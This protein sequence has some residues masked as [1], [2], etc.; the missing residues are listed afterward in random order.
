MKFRLT[1]SLL[2][3]YVLI[4]LCAMVLLPLSFPI[5]IF[6]ISLPT[7]VAGG[8]AGQG[9]LYGN[10]LQLERMWHEEAGKLGGAADEAIDRRLRELKA[11]Y[12][13]ANLFWVDE[14]GATRL[15]LPE[16]PA[17]PA[18]WTAAFTVEFMK[19]RSG[20]D[21]FT[22][23]AFLG[24]GADADGSFMVFE[25]PRWALK[26]TAERVRD[27]NGTA[28]V[29]G[30]L[31]LFGSFL[32]VSLLF[33]YRIR[34]RL[35][36]LQNAMT[37]P[38]GSGI[39]GE[40]EVLKM[41]EIG[42]LESA[43]NDMV[44]QLEESRR[45]EAEEETLRRDLF[46][47]LSHD[48]R[49]PLTAIR[50]H[51]YGLRNEPL[52]DKAA[53]S[54][55][56]IERKTDYAGR[57]IDNLFSYSL[58]AAGKYPYRPRSVDIVRTVRTVLTG[59]Y[60]LFEQAGFAIELELPEEAVWW[61]VD[62]EWLERVLDNYCQNVLRHAKAG[63]YVRL[64]VETVSGGRIVIA[65][66]GPGMGGESAEKGTGLGLSIAAMMLKEMGLRGDIRSGAEG[67]TITIARPTFLNGF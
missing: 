40:V 62:P 51:A 57:L 35:V 7:L 31:F 21:P 14:T 25:L 42:R 36:R 15:Q 59:W 1:R 10:A 50:S 12:P 4:I 58:L 16:N 20:G 29:S 37:E 17:L 11:A 26:G 65:D 43:F 63:R 54:V 60:P 8:S 34:S 6:L 19:L 39:P 24:E 45:R 52:T 41:D 44:R 5:A 32:A 46:A 2:S 55:E 56:L 48:L 13:V 47:R 3:K 18:V 61:N 38:N 27:R 64:A 23:V 9:A 49:T 67:T 22:V 53:A 33:F 66:R 30:M 28:L